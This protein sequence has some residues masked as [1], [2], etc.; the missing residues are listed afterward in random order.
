MCRISGAAFQHLLPRVGQAHDHTPY[1]HSVKKEFLDL[2]HGWM[3]WKRIWKYG[4]HWSL[5]AL[6]PEKE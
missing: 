1:G 4:R 2:R 3:E 6:A 5:Q